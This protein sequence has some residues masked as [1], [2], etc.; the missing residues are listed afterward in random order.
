[1]LIPPGLLAVVRAEEPRS[2]TRG[3]IEFS[4]AVFADRLAFGCFRSH[5]VS[6]AE[7]FDGVDRDAQSIRYSSISSPLLTHGYDFFLL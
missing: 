5:T 6:S 7:S 2:C 3:I 1:M 4:A